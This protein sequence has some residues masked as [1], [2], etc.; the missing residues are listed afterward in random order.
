MASSTN[1]I[2]EYLGLLNMT[3]RGV[4]AGTLAGLVGASAMFYV[5][6]VMKVF[7]GETPIDQ[8]DAWQLKSRDLMVDGKW[9]WLWI[10]LSKARAPCHRGLFRWV[11]CRCTVTLLKVMPVSFL[12]GAPLHSLRIQTEV[13]FVRQD[14]A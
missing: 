3:S 5:V 10:V 11:V 14:G 6:T 9:V 2:A 1:T 8:N 13:L 12:F 7:G 4:F